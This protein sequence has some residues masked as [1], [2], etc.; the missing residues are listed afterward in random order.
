MVSKYLP[1][2]TIYYLSGQ[3]S[4]NNLEGLRSKILQGKV[5]K[6]LHKKVRITFE[7]KGRKISKDVK[8]TNVARS[9]EQLL[10]DFIKNHP[11]LSLRLTK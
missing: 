6:N 7:A 5:E 3:Y 11:Q 8:T 10:K 9:E 1:G 2:E 4:K